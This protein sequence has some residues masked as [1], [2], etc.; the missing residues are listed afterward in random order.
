VSNKNWFYYI[1]V[2]ITWLVYVL[3]TFSAPVTET[4]K[5]YGLTQPTLDALRITVA[6][7]LLII[8]LLAIYG[9]LHLKR[10][11]Q[12]IEKG[13]D[14]QS[15]HKMS[16][17]LFVL[18]LGMISSSLFGT[19]RSLNIYNPEIVVIMTILTNYLNVITP[20]IAYFL[21][22]QSSS[23]LLHNI[24]AKA[25]SQVHKLLAL[26]PL[27]ILAALYIWL[28]LSNPN[29]QTPVSSDTA[30]SFYLSDPLIFLTI[31]IPVVIAWGLGILSVLNIYSYMKNVQGIIYKQS[32]KYMAFGIVGVV[33]A[34][35][36]TQ[37]LL[38]LGATRLMGVS[39]G[40][41]LCIVYVLLAA[42]ALGYVLIALG[43]KKLSKIEIV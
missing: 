26:L 29:R 1:A 12:T 15:L 33:G 30:A 24:N 3:L 25:V 27:G 19:I 39:L 40:W 20:L 9:A 17:G 6:L 4:S 31:I 2:F 7:P 10:Y 5:K 16:I 14:G 42:I 43:S 13:F 28:T 23:K 11:A 35:I 18:A 41:L 8:W 21:I 38:A 36:L 37:A 32:L 22:F 34:S